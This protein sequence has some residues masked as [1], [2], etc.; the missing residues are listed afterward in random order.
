M[1]E[2]RKVHQFNCFSCHTPSQVALTTYLKNEEAY[3]GLGKFLQAKRDYF[4]ELMKQTRFEL[5]PSSGSYFICGTYKSISDEAD[6]DLAIRLTKEAGVAT[7]PL[8]AF[9][10]DGKDDRVLRF[11]FA[12][13]N[14]TLEGAVNRLMKI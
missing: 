5:L 1:K 10:Q 9:Y 2:F 7:I 14:E 12:K 4:I 8:S 13:K 6:K 3:T 11:C